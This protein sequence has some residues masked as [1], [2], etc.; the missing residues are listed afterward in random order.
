MRCSSCSTILSH[1]SKLARQN[2]KCGKCLGM[3]GKKP[4]LGDYV[5]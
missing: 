4:H 2:Q 1:P 5:H 3:R